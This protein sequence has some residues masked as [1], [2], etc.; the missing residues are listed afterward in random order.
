MDRES[1]WDRNSPLLSDWIA[2]A[3]YNKQR[4]RFNYEW[5]NDD[6]NR[7]RL[8][9]EEHT[10]CT[11]VISRISG[12]SIQTP[13]LRHMRWRTVLIMYR[14]I[15]TSCLDISSHRSPVRSDQRSDPG[16]NF[17]LASGPALDFNRRRIFRRRSGFCIHVCVCQK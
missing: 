11:G 2:E 16:S 3:F 1:C 5:S 9:W 17:W 6:D 12:A 8:F 15:Q 13:K 7:H 4:K 14:L 10:S